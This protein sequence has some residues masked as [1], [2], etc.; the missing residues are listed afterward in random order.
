[1]VIKTDEIKAEMVNEINDKITLS[2]TLIL[3]QVDKYFQKKRWLH[4]QAQ[5]VIFFWD[6]QLGLILMRSTSTINNSQMDLQCTFCAP[7]SPDNNRC[8]MIAS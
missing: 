7:Q 1:M 8:K 3:N 5:P 4:M 2:L 6:N